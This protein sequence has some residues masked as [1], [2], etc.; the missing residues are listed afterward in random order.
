MKESVENSD[1]IYKETMN[2]PWLLQMAWRDSRRNRARL[3]LF[4]SSVV[5]GIAALVAIYS[6]GD[7]LRQNIDNQAASL[8][9]ADLELS[10]NRPAG[11]KMQKLIDS[12]GTRRSEERSF[13]SMIYFPKNGGSR[14]VQIRA[15]QGEFPYYGA[16]ET[17]PVSA[18][19]AF[20]N[21]RQA[22]VDQTLMLQ[23][24]AQVG[25]SIKVGEVTFAIAGVLLKA[26]GQTGIST[27]AAPS[28]YIPLRYLSQTGLAQKGSRIRYKYFF[29][30]APQTNA[31]QLVKRI[32]PRLDVEGM[33][34][35]TIESQKEDT[36][37]SF[38]DL[39]RFLSLVGFIALLLGCIGVA[40]AIHIYVREKLNSIAVLRC[41][42]VKA[43]QAFLIYLIQITGIGIVGSLLGALLG[44]L[45]QQFLPLVIQDFLPIEVTTDIS[46][47]AIGQGLALGVL[48]SILF[49]LL[50][51]LSIRKVSP[52]T[53]LR[54]SFEPTRRERDPLAWLVY[55]LILLFIFGF[56]V[57]QMKNWREALVFTGSVLAAFFVLIGMAS[58]LIWLVRRFFPTSWSYLWRQ[59][60]ANLYRP[61][62]QTVI[63]MVSIGLGTAFICT[64]F[65]VQTILLSRVTL[66]SSGNQPNMVLFDIQAAQREQVLALARQQGLPVDQTVPIV[67]MRLE[68][69]NGYTAAEAQKDTT[70][71]VPRWLYGREYRI[72]FRDSLTPSEKV[73]EGAWQGVAPAPGLPAISLEQGFARRSNISLGDTLSFNV[74]GSLISTV[75]G[76]FREVDWN[77]IQ[78]NFVVVFPTG[79]LEDAP[80]FHVL[81]THVPSQE[82]SA[83]FQQAMVRQFPNVSII[84]LGLVLKVLDDLFEKIGFVIRFMAGFSILTGL[85][86]LV[87]SVLISKFQRIQESVLLR[88]LGASR[89]QI[90]AITALE[91]FFLGALAAAT[92]I[93]LALAGSWALARFSFE[94]E[95]RPELLPVLVIFGLVSLIT[96]FIG[97]INSRGI[98]SR[99]P[100]EVLRQ[101]V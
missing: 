19:G 22:L 84:D 59:G 1:E 31:A 75:V 30:L 11:P 46:W 95:F 47:A 92:G 20:R 7:N 5:L 71:D 18:S 53:V 97:L 54:A 40:S 29:E 70:I 21:Q 96:V 12:L 49:A 57:L 85:V 39:T 86:V 64:L 6:L 91:Y 28:V 36:G 51:L 23:Y 68:E 38:R 74:Q 69:V 78:T 34:Y 80:Q 94:T 24:E 10:G 32:K 42:G 90:F 48:I 44:T 58:L 17:T 25:D 50:P 88:T 100:L 65:F 2:F 52:L 3:L 8:L 27:T 98:L 45:I 13:P 73:T 56:T 14:L 35:E 9:G 81:L 79:V 55:G 89:R 37:R 43:S 62:N 76:S 101:D 60:L 15:L 87:A 63:L 4:I 61:N 93:L 77:R 72:T 99:P 82:V 33:N 26:P 41:M 66:S 67:T 16:L 83:R